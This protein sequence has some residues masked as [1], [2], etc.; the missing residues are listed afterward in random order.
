MPDLVVTE[1][2]PQLLVHYDF[3]EGSD[4][5]ITNAVG[6]NGTLVNAHGG[7]W[8]ESGGVRGSGYLNF[9]NTTGNGAD[10]QHILTGLVPEDA[11][12][13]GDDAEYT[14]MAWTR[15]A[16]TAPGGDD[17]D[18]MIFGQ[19][20]ENVLHNGARGDQYYMGHWAND[21]G[22]GSVE[23][24]EWHH[25]AWRYKEGNLEIFV[26]GES[27]GTDAKLG[28][29]D[30]SEIIIGATRNDQDRDFSGDLDDVR[31][32]DGAISE[33]EIDAVVAFKPRRG[34]PIAG[35]LGYWPEEYETTDSDHRNLGTI[36]V[37]SADT[38]FTWSFWVDANETGTSDV[39]LG[40]RFG[41][42]GFDLFP[43]EWIKF[44]PTRFEWR[45]SE[46]S[47]HIRNELT[48]F[49]TSV[50]A[51][52]L[53][54]QDGVTLTYHRDGTVIGTNEITD[55]PT[56][57]LP[58]FLGGQP[59]SNGSTTEGFS[60]TLKEVAIF[61]RALS[62]AE[63]IEVYTRGLN[64]QSLGTVGG[65]PE[66]AEPQQVLSKIG[67]G[68]NG[69]FGFDLPDNVTGEI[70]Y[71]TDLKNWEVIATGTVGGFDDTDATRA[72]EPAG[73]YRAK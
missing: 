41:A 28:F 1:K 50:W 2:I 51:H 13:L 8:V 48:L 18:S 27:V 10:A 73:Y 6:P 57:E 49:E 17:E 62:E 16:T 29:R 46:D 67:F 32:Y 14:M 56:N 26:D 24:D 47:N 5:T 44:T 52:Y 70:E 11:G 59:T 4:T 30:P 39:V 58:L 15:F 45:H 7:A 72:G 68:V 53:V 22:A 33:A 20:G 60:G 61:D 19:F 38:G 34:D 25:V 42:D 54:V 3:N 12:L 37:L 63:V 69:A 21:L 66:P 43:R 36:P 40:N 9:N 71:S 35:L 31:I 55:F 23:V 65:D 64:D